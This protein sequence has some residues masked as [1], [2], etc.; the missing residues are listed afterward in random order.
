MSLIRAMVEVQRL[1][2]NR[3]FIK[4][5]LTADRQA[6]WFKVCRHKE[7]V[8]IDNNSFE[9][10]ATVSGEADALDVLAQ[11]SKEAGMRAALRALAAARLPD[12]AILAVSQA[13]EDG[14]ADQFL[15]T[16]FK[17]MIGVIAEE[18]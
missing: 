2:A 13:C 5:D 7:N 18:P 8:V 11:L 6:Q 9:V 3:W 17:A 1:E 14:N 12:R 10:M 16:L 15:E 4:V